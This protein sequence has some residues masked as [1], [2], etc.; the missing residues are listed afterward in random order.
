M[1]AVLVLLVAL[2]GALSPMQASLLDD[3]TVITWSLFP[4]TSTITG[5]PVA[6]V[7][8]P[9]VELPLFGIA[10]ID[11]SDTN[12]LITALSSGTAATAAFNGFRFQ[13]AEVVLSSVTINNATVPLFDASRLS[14]D[15]NNIYV[16]FS[17]LTFS[18]GQVVSLDVSGTGAVPEPGSAAMLGL[19]LLAV[20]LGRSAL[21]RTR[22]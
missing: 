7:V 6:S 19:G 12:I 3:T 5:G 22:H 21:R 17:G 1:K 4:D 9:G 10:S 2:T 16:D 8:G 11:F 13:D 20:L 14:F 15:A 18:A